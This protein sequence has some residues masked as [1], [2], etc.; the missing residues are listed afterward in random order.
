MIEE[1]T[2]PSTEPHRRR[3]AVVL[4]ADVV[5]Y[6]RLMS[7]NEEATLETLATYQE[8]VGGMVA[9]HQGRVFGMA[10]DSIMAAFDSAVQAVRCAV[11]IQR[12]LQ[13]RN[14]DLPERRRR[15]ILERPPDPCFPPP[16]L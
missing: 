2:A 15:V 1:R 7:E 4:A 9:A 14:V 5:G 13:R 10:G 3:L 8:V 12:G 16:D 6:S 11:E